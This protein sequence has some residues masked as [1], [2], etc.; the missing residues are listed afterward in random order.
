[1]R[2]FIC[3]RPPS[4]PLQIQNYIHFHP[5]EFC[6]HSYYIVYF[7]TWADLFPLVCRYN[8]HGE[9]R[10]L[11]VTLIRIW[12]SGKTPSRLSQRSRTK[13]G[14]NRTVFRGRVKDPRDW[15]QLWDN[16]KK[17]H[18][19]RKVFL[20]TFYFETGQNIFFTLTISVS[21]RGSRTRKW[22]ASSQRGEVERSQT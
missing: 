21:S 15:P 13:P 6:Q 8:N 1:M 16:W 12:L 9:V 5:K 17:K 19:K 18:K 7:C 14:S 4:L 22:K 11:S 20:N 10:T 3:A 2:I